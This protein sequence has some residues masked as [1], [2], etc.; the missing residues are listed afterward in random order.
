MQNI[1]TSI[2]LM[3]FASS[4]RRL[5]ASDIAGSED[6]T[7][8]FRELKSQYEAA[9][10]CAANV[11]QAFKDVSLADLT[12]AP[13][14]LQS[15]TAS[16]DGDVAK[17]SKVQEQISD[18]AEKMELSKKAMKTVTKLYHALC[19]NEKAAAQSSAEQG[20]EHR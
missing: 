12:K 13:E 19:M 9:T 20:V 18:L 15:M 2:P 1:L 5:L 14:I 11:E 17:I 4:I 10:K 3:A 16:L 7:K 8:R 6:F